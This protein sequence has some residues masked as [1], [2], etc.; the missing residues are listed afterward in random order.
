MGAEGLTLLVLLL[1]LL[2]FRVD[3]LIYSVYV[4]PQHSR[5]PLLN[6]VSGNTR[7]CDSLQSAINALVNINRQFPDD[8]GQVIVTSGYY[9]ACS[10]VTFKSTSVRYLEIIGED[11]NRTKLVCSNHRFALVEVDALGLSGAQIRLFNLSLEAA[12]I[13]S[14]QGTVGMIIDQSDLTRMGSLASSVIYSSPFKAK[15]LNLTVRFS[16]VYNFA[17]FV[18]C[19]SSVGEN[20]NAII[21]RSTFLN[22]VVIFEFMSNFL[23]ANVCV[24]DSFFYNI[25]SLIQSYSFLL[26]NL[27][28]LYGFI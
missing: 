26:Y 1:L 24:K 22:I 9:E 16:R 12:L 18:S 25:D 10:T 19:P 20:I 23:S 13:S 6:C 4:D 21:D 11:R 14:Y 3:G 8:L 7:A 17:K 15:N 27:E 5:Y 2:L 28:I